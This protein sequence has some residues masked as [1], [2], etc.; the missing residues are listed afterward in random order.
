MGNVLVAGGVTL[1]ILAFTTFLKARSKFMRSQDALVAL[2]A[3]LCLHNALTAASVGLQDWPEFQPGAR[4][5]LRWN[6]KIAG[7]QVLGVAMAFL[8][9]T[10]IPL[11]AKSLPDEVAGQPAAWDAMEQRIEEVKAAEIVEPQALEELEAALQALRGKPENDWFSHESLETTD[12]LQESTEA[13][14]SEL[15]KN[16]ESAL[17]AMEVSRQLESAQM[18]ALSP[19]LQKISAE[20]LKALASG[21]MPLNEKMLS[22][23]KGLDPST[24]RQLS[25][26]EWEKIKA[27]MSQGISTCS[28]GFSSGDKAGDALLAVVLA[29]QGG[30]SRGPGSAPFALKD[31][32]TNLKTQSIERLENSD[33]RHAALGDLVGLGTGEHQVDESAS[34]AAGTLA[35]PSAAGDSPSSVN[36]S[37]SEQKVLQQ[38][39]R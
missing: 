11:P 23:L 26:E 32:E 7:L 6:L 30:V 21:T 8:A 19:E 25:A 34:G 9:A 15:A 12:H 24:L 13:A 17:A 20:A 22:N 1:F 14:L 27:K 33:L 28:N 16:L 2:E 38:F 39:F 37:P 5:N 10:L 4:L 31:S 18:A 35:N 36:A 3:D 29:S